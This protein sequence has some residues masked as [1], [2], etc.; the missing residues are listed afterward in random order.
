MAQNIVSMPQPGTRNAPCFKGKY[1]SDFIEN[2]HAAT[3]AAGIPDNDLPKLVLRYC[4]PNVRMVIKN[5]IAFSGVDWKAAS[6]R[7]IFLYDSGDAKV[8]AHPERLNKFVLKCAKKK[9]VK[10]SKTLDLYHHAF[11]KRVGDMLTTNRM[12]SK[13]VDLAFYHGLPVRLR[14]DIKSDLEDTV[15]GKLSDRNPPKLDETIKVVRAYFDEDDIDRG[16]A[17][18]SDSSDS[19]SDSEADDE[20]SDSD[21]DSDD[22]EDDDDG[23][24]KK[25]KKKS[26]GKDSDDEDAFGSESEDE[27]SKKKK[28]KNKNWSKNKK[29]NSKKN[30]Q[31]KDKEVSKLTNELQRLQILVESLKNPPV[32]PPPVATSAAAFHQAQLARRC[33]MCDGV[34]GSTLTHPIGIRQCPETERLIKDGLI[35]FNKIGRLVKADGSDLPRAPPGCGGIAAL[36]RSEEWANRVSE[37]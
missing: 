30:K 16:Y 32:L 25:K 15:Q 20:S 14:K 11:K 6:E 17:S 27:K 2:F 4:V 34:E 3:K 5:D 18:F 13:Q 19:D 21:D 35:E 22:D 31:K 29:K 8:K 36:L 24:F 33:Y 7:L 37:G 26:K 10:G 1:P 9:V 23:L 12:T 28:K